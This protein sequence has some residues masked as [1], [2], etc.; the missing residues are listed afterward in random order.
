MSAW[1]FQG[2]PNVFDMDSY[3][4]SK[5]GR[6][7][8]L[9]TRY[10]NEIKQ[11]DKVYFW[12][13]A[14]KAG[15]DSGVIASGEV[16]SDVRELQSES[17]A[18][19]H[20]SDKTQS[21]KV[22]PRVWVVLTKIANSKEVLKRDWF[23]D[24]AILKNMLIMRQASGTNF[25]LTDIEADRISLAW[26]RVG[27]NWTRSESI[28][29]LW[30]YSKIN[31]GEVSQRIGSPVEIVSSRTGRSSGG[32]YN[33]VMNFR[34]IDPNDTRKGMSGA[35]EVDRGVWGEFFDPIANQLVHV[36]I[37]IEFD[38]L[39]GDQASEPTVTYTDYYSE[40][41][42]FDS[43]VGKLN[44]Q[45]IESLLAQYNKKM[46]LPNSEKLK[47]R[48]Y[49]AN[50]KL[51]KRD[52]LVV[53]IAQK[54]AEF[55]CEIATCKTEKFINADGILFCEVHHIQPLAEGGT[56]RIENVICLCASHHR[57]A[58]FGR[59]QLALKEYFLGIRR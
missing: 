24:D 49:R 36:A 45:N 47:P 4:H 39:W 19:R 26:S 16:V 41:D 40:L 59:N 12:R 38:R 17:E 32:V 56:D 30:A 35:G 37:Q 43:E 27:K 6:I 20:W 48:I 44:G 8:W 52:P 2:N 54:R 53:A 28:A 57:E 50:A 23:K 18:V 42:D 34:A 21:A 14:G 22:S 13:S 9:V 51:F 55:M 1:I 25:R 11:G 3:F 58:H 46:A 29:G 15:A 10:R 31:G 33:K 5:P 7:T